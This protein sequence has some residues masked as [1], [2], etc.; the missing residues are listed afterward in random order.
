[1]N[2]YKQAQQE[3]NRFEDRNDFNHRIEVMEDTVAVLTS[4]AQGIHEDPYRSKKVISDI[5]N[6]KFFSSFPDWQEMLRIADF[7]VLDNHKMASEIVSEVAIG[8]VGK[9]DAMKKQRS[10]FIHNEY[11]ISFKEKM[12]N[13]HERALKRKEDG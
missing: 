10:D 9:I 6:N 1:M 13:S 3:L 11:P 8:L 5:A 2:W 4:M 12:D 7:K